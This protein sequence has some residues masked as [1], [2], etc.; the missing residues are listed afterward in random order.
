MAEALK[1]PALHCTAFQIR[2]DSHC[3]DSSSTEPASPSG[4]A[5]DED[6]TILR[7]EIREFDVLHSTQQVHL[8]P[9]QASC[10]S[11][12]GIA[13]DMISC[14]EQIRRGTYSLTDLCTMPY[15]QVRNLFH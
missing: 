15:K 12:D 9:S 1:V 8:P 14:S 6:E 3:D 13:S 2:P 10:Q 5:L 4:K 11:Q 7:I